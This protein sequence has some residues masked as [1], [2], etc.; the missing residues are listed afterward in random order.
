MSGNQQER[1][2]QV[3]RKQ[4]NSPLL[5]FWL[6]LIGLSS[7]LVYW[8]AYAL[9]DLRRQTADF[10]IIFFLLFVLY[11]A[12]AALI[13]RHEPKR[14]SAATWIVIML[15]AVAPRLLLLPMK[16]TLSD[17]MFRYVWDGRVQNNGLSPYQYP[18]DA[19]EVAQFHTD[20]TTVWPHIN[21]KPY[22][23]IYPPGAQIAY[24]IIWR[25]VGDSITGFKA[26]FVLAELVGAWLLARLL[27]ALDQP[28][29][30][31]LIYLWSPLLIFEVAHAG[32][33]DGL[34][35]PFL[36][37][38][39]WAR[40]KEYY[41]LLGL[42]LGLAVLVKLMPLLLLPVLLP[43]VKMRIQGE[44]AAVQGKE[45]KKIRGIYGKVSSGFDA[46]RRWV[47][48]QNLR[49]ILYVAVGLCGVVILAYLPYV[50]S[51]GSPIGFLPH[52]FS[53]NFNMGFARI[54][55]AVAD[56]YGRSGSTLINLITFGGLVCL[57]LIFIFKPAPDNAP[58]FTRCVWLIG[59]FTLFTQ[60]LFPWYLLWLLPL[61]T[62]LVQPGKFL[63]F[64]LAPT[65]AWLFFSGLIM[66]SYLF[67]IHWRIVLWA[68][69]AE[70]VPLY[71]LLLAGGLKDRKKWF[72]RYIY[73]YGAT[74]Q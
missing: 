50:L 10:V 40:I 14:V 19:A 27:Q 53:E 21:R 74:S 69:I 6:T 56:K 29:Q 36:V 34:M 7:L 5:P 46:F 30:R 58:I 33:V 42:A 4:V 52:Y 55:F 9:E 37:L 41:W 68:Q 35:L 49:Q 71:A 22:V 18:P 39:L 57:S 25:I 2:Q 28:P 16:P 61:L 62:C 17:D 48:Q 73:H 51:E 47:T 65:T 31:V 60:N 59:W 43:P 72:T 3:V 8:K 13:L 54:V 24:A 63:G 38:A 66:L 67:F 15:F 12:A 64:K 26:V 44:G 70:F 20:D 23:T 1:E 11:L 32:H 45:A